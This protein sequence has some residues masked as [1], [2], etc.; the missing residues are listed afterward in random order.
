MAQKDFAAAAAHFAKAVS[1]VETDYVSWAV[2]ATC[3]QAVGR[4]EDVGRAARMMVSQ[5]S[6]VLAEDPNNGSALGVCAGGLAILGE[7]ERAKKQID[8]ALLIDPD[9]L[10]LRYNFACVLAAYLDEQDSALDLLE[11]VMEGANVTL[12]NAAAV[13]PDFDSLRANSRF[14]QLLTDAEE[15]LGKRTR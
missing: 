8:R 5:S 4:S 6:K 7:G 12:I 11:P 14:Q 9:N 2:L 3:Y 15:R 13:D 1:I 10:N